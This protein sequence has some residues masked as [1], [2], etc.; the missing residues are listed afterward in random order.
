LQKMSERLDYEG[1]DAKD[2]KIFRDSLVNNVREMLSLLTSFN[3]TQDQ[4]MENMRVQLE[5]A[6]MGVSADALR[7][8]D[9]FRKETKSKV[10]SILKSMSW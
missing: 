4:R 6:M 1:G 5:D 3:V 9:S 7:E 2:K 10:D 8:D